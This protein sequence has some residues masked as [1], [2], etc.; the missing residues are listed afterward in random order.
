[1]AKHIYT[2]SLS[3]I[4]TYQNYELKESPSSIV[5]ILTNDKSS[6]RFKKLE[7]PNLVS[8]FAANVFSFCMHCN[9]KCTLFVV[10]NDVLP[11]DSLNSG[12]L[13][14]IFNQMNLPPAKFYRTQP[15]IY[16][17]NLYL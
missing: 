2:I 11:Y 8:D 14:D 13:V 15:I 9:I 7:A 12:P 10:Y 3:S 1:M 5:R 17:N 16:S 6:R 4:A